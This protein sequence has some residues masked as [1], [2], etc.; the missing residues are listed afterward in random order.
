MLSSRFVPVTVNVFVAVVPAVT[1]P[2]S[3]LVGVA[4]ILGV[5]VLFKI[6]SMPANALIMPLPL[7][8][9]GLAGLL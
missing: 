8:L 4:E 6:Y 1:L 2:K 3:R 7:C 5:V 9:A